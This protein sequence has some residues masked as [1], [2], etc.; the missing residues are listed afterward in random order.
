MRMRFVVDEI[1]N[2]VAKL[3]NIVDGNIIYVN[4]N[5][6]PNEVKETDVLL[7]QDNNYILDNEKK[8]ERYNS[9]KEK[10]ERLRNNK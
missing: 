7:Y 9:I 4:V 3:E 8:E 10:F 6:L 2:D 1:I 5:I